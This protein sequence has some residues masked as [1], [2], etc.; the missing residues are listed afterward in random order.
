M[1]KYDVIVIGGGPAGMMAAISASKTHSVCLIDKNKDLGKKLLLT[2]GGRCNVTN[3]KPMDEFM[4]YIPTNPRFLYSSFDQ[5]SNTDIISFFTSR[6]TP[7]KE[8]DHGRIFPK[9]DQASSILNTLKNELHANHVDILYESCVTSILHD[10]HHVTGVCINNNETIQSDR[11]ILACGGASF[12]HTGSCKENFALLEPFNHTITPLLASEVGLISHEFFIEDKSLMG[13]SLRNVTLSILNKKGKVQH[14]F[15]NDLLFTHFGIS[16]PCAL[17]ASS[18]FSTQTKKDKSTTM[19]LELNVFP[20]KT[21]EDLNNLFASLKQEAPK[22][23][24][25]NHIKSLICESY[26]IFILKIVDIPM[27]TPLKSINQKQM[28]ALIHALLH[29]TFK[30]SNTLSLESAFVTKGGVSTKEINPK[31]M[32][33]K[34]INGLSFCGECMDV[35][36]HTGGYNITIALSTGYV[37]GIHCFD[38]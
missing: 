2:G 16:G 20:N 5:F 13:V 10:E 24:I 38:E 37:A 15:T 27:D 25:K 36:G 12:K 26:A 14:S 9:S 1:K 32:Q 7:L 35:N 17:M 23:S 11:I 30:V 3:S 6:N 33:S 19:Q 28:K 29:F 4:A 18:Y 31:T 8:E 34:K 21:E 22:K